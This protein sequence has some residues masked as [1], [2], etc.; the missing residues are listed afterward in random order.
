MTPLFPIIE[1]KSTLLF[2]KLDNLT[3][4]CMSV[5]FDVR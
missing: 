2:K 3:L 4:H 1:K 5:F